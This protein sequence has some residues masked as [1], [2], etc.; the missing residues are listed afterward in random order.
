ML[1]FMSV[2]NALTVRTPIEKE[3]QQILRLELSVTVQIQLR[4]M[5]CHGLYFTR[6]VA[7]Q[8]YLD[9]FNC[10]NIPLLIPIISMIKHCLG[11][12]FTRVLS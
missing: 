1:D 5:A 6:F 2:R 11:D 7:K 8:M 9:T 3:F 10:S 12:A 4:K